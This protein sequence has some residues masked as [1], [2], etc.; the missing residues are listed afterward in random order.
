[1]QTMRLRCWWQLNQEVTHMLG[2]K[3][4]GTP[5]NNPH[6]KWSEWWSSGEPTSLLMFSVCWLIH[7]WLKH[8]KTCWNKIWWYGMIRY[9]MVHLMT[10]SELFWFHNLK[11]IDSLYIYVYVYI[12]IHIYIYIYIHIYIHIYLYTYIYI[13]IYIYIFINTY[14]YIYIPIHIYIIIIII[15]MIIIMIIIIIYVQQQFMIIIHISIYTHIYIYSH[16]ISRSG[17]QGFSFV[18]FMGARSS[19]TLPCGVL[20]LQ[21]VGIRWSCW[22]GNIMGFT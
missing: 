1:M 7:S 9:D 13:C 22:A 5:S 21:L 16:I 12:Y 14:I 6:W 18:R 15:I 8:V 17:F 19:L 3:N 2:K 4:T 10:W 11:C 20:E